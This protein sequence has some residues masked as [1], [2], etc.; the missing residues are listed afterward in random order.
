MSQ[1]K[2]TDRAQGR[3]K[4]ILPAL[5]IAA[6]ALTGK[7]GP[8]PVCGGKDRFRFDDKQGR[9]T[10][11]CNQSHGT[12]TAKGQGSAGNGFAL[13]MDK[14]GCDFAQA[15]RLVEKVIG[16]TSEP[17]P[18][19]ATLPAAEET[20]AAIAEAK[21]LWRSGARVTNGDP[22]DLYLRNRVGTYAP[23]RAIKFV[24][25]TLIGGR[26]LP[27]MLTAYVDAHGDLFGVQRTFL[28]LDG[29]KAG[30]KPDRWNH[31][32]LPD[33]GAVR[34]AQPI[35]GNLGIAEG[36]ETALAATALYGFPCWAALTANRLEVWEPPAGIDGVI[37]FG[38]ND[39]NCVGQSAAYA[40]AQRLNRSMSCQVMIPPDAGTDWNNVLQSKPHSNPPEG[41]L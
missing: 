9:G 18:Q 35:R 24:P 7:H 6:T 37:V 19:P 3:W 27:A 22:V 34:L 5:G 4:E 12:D 14:E 33:G 23:T 16:K 36:V 31:G 38:D 2:I 26:T 28:T 8:C 25:E 41:T 15:A 21:A 1:H 11:Y 40:L 10:W 13:L 29:H 39:V 17:I 30:V 20:A 32:R